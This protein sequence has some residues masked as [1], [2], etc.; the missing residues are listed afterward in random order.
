MNLNDM[1]SEMLCVAFER[2]K[3]GGIKADSKSLFKHMAGEVI[4]AEE[5]FFFFDNEVPQVSGDIEFMPDELREEERKRLGGELA[6]V[7][8]CALLI[9][10][11]EN[12]DIEKAVFDCLEKNKKR[13]LGN[14][15]KL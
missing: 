15:D 6:D 10:A 2:E 4:E 9:C 12:I 5:A 1:A 13:A 7:I 14:G 8:A 11:R 3:H